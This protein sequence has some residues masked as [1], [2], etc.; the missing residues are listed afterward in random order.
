MAAPALDRVPVKTHGRVIF[1]RTAEIDWVEAAGNY[2]TLHVGRDQHMLRRTMADM[3]ACLD[4]DLFV[5]IHRSRI[6][7]VDR[8]RELRPL[9]GGEW[10]VILHDGVRLTLSRGYRDQLHTRL[11]L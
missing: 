11:G 8:I 1:V 9:D 10:L 5:R 4:P 6:V 3:E 2:V 7:N